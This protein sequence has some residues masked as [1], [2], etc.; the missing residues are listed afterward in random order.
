MQKTNRTLLT[1]N[2]S[3]MTME[4]HMAGS[5]KKMLDKIISEK[6]KGSVTMM[7]L[8]KTKLILKG[9]NPDKFT[10]L[11]DDDPAIIQKVRIIAKEMDITI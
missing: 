8:T 3:L 6:S 10:Q 7:N 4:E 9:L 5:I 11:S 2:T 1:V